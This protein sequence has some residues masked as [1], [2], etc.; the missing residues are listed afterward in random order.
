MFK[1]VSKKSMLLLGAAMALCA[2][3]LPSVASA[4]SWSPVG[5]TDG[6]LDSANLG[7]SIPANGSGWFCGA[8]SFSVTVDS[9]AV[10]TIA[11]ASFTQCSGDLGG[12]ANCLV[13]AV[14]TNFPWRATAV[15][16]NNIQIHGVDIDVQFEGPGGLC[17]SDGLLIRLTGTV[18]GAFFTPGSAGSTRRIDLAGSTGLVAHFSGL[19]TTAVPRGSVTATGLLNIFD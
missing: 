6:R 13:T 7:F 12:A 10:A 4:A 14:G 8:T 2:F 1:M 19:T 18:T 17:S 16:T 5:T 11:N 3:V 9:A 15:A